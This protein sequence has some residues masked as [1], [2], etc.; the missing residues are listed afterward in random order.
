MGYIPNAVNDNEE[1]SEETQDLKKA[2]RALKPLYST[3]HSKKFNNVDPNE[4]A[5]DL[6]KPAYD[7]QTED[8]RQELPNVRTFYQR[9]NNYRNNIPTPPTSLFH[10]PPRYCYQPL[11]IVHDCSE[12]RVV[13]NFWFY[14]Y[15]ADECMLYAADICDN[16]RNKFLSL[17]R[18]EEHCAVPMRNLPRILEQQQQQGCREGQ[19]IKRNFKKRRDYV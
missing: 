18:C 1:Y 5:V 11:N 10:L 17:E 9:T 14:N 19:F 16:N 4:E 6:A 8:L 2:N 7:F 15:C 13:G 3:L 12:Q